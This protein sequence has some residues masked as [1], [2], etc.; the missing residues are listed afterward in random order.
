MIRYGSY[1]RY[2]VMIAEDG[3]LD[4]MRLKV[5]MPGNCLKS[6]EEE[7]RKRLNKAPSCMEQILLAVKEREVNYSSDKSFP[8]TD[9]V[10]GSYFYGEHSL[11]R[12]T[13]MKNFTVTKECTGCGVCVSVCPLN[14]IKITNQKAVH[15]HDC[16]ACY[17]CLHWCPQNATL[18]NVPTL[19]HRAQYHHPEIMLKEIAIQKSN[20]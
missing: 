12:L 11:K 7:N 9:Y 5:Q 14:N 6:S 4:T 17:A 15:G 20:I 8:A 10:T 18:L 16:A 2:A 13:L 3:S 19:K 1:G